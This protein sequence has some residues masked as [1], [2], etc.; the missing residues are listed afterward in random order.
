MPPWSFLIYTKNIMYSFQFEFV[1][2]INNSVGRIFNLTQK[3]VKAGNFKG[4]C[5]IK[6]LLKIMI[7]QADRR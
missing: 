7:K 1:C 4:Q 5:R 2:E 6:V 3:N